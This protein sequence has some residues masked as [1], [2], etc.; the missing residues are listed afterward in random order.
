[1]LNT[2][3]KNR[4]VTQTIV[5]DNNQG[6]F[7]QLDWDA[8]YDGNIANLSVSSNND[9]K[10]EQLNVSL[11]NEDLANILNYPSVNIPIH[12]RLKNDFINYKL[13]EPLKL[14]EK[15]E[16]IEEIIDSYISS[17]KTDEQF[18]V[19]ITI[20][21]KTTT[22]RTHATYK[23]Y[24]KHRKSSK[25]RTKSKSKSSSRRSSKTKSNRKSSTPITL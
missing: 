19:P 9:G 25:S 10:V 20:N 17:P 24:K 15:P 4:G 6:H 3:I 21:K 2:Y 12:K 22:P 8:D 11:D 18:I 23:V 5:Y 7:N 13:T 16:S 1:M 14:L